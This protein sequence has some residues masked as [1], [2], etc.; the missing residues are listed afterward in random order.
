MGLEPSK[1]GESGHV[2][3][4]PGCP[5]APGWDGQWDWS[6]L[7]QD[8]RDMFGMSLGFLRLRDGM[9]SGP[10]VVGRLGHV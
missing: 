6:H 7:E 1:V 10:S 5:R 2:W 4:V 3:D 8:T 9:D